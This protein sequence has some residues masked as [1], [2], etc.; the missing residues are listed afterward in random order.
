MS[1][2][3][4]AVQQL[5]IDEGL[6]LVPYRDTVGVLTIG[7]GRNLDHVGI[8]EAEATLMLRRDVKVAQRD[9]QELVGPSWSD[10]TAARQAV[11]INMA[12]NLGRTRL[13]QFTK[14][15][16]AI[17]L[18][19]YDTAASEMLNSRWATQ[20]GNRATRLADAMRTG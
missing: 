1:P 12:F 9:A 8:T 5:K 3:E 4:M 6:S 10:L 7:Y 19:H 13:S 2:T 18:H 14:T 17:R 11:V 15:L 20:V 16:N